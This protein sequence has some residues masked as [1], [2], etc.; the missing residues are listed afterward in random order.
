MHAPYRL[1]RQAVDGIEDGQALLLVVLLEVMFL[2][3]SSYD[4]LQGPTRLT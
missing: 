4:L 1:T 2:R 3:P